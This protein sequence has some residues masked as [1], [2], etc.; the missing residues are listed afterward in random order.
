MP[1]MEVTEKDVKGLLA[2]IEKRKAFFMD[3]ADEANDNEEEA[4]KT[5]MLG[6]YDALVDMEALITGGKKVILTDDDLFVLGFKTKS[7]R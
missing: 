6:S 5:M 7:K 3:K 2:Q 4:I 1:M